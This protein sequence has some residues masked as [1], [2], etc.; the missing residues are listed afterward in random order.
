M[1]RPMTGSADNGW[2]ASAQAWIASMGDVG[3]FSRQYVL[4]PPMLARVRQRGF[5][6]ALDVGCGEGRFCRLLHA[7]G[8]ATVGVEPSPSLRR[9]A[10]ARDPAGDYVEAVAE[11]LPFPAESFDLVVCYLTLID[12]DDIDAAI[13]EAVRVLKPGG[14]L[15]IAN[16]NSFNTAGVWR[17]SAD[18][19]R[20]FVLDNYLAERREWAN[21]SGISVQNWHRPFSRYMRP[22]LDAGLR[23]IYFDEPAPVGGNET[24][25]ARY[26]RSPWFHIMEWRKA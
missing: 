4:D 20:V 10:L 6:R 7:E 23:L 5:M 25:A 14:S 16:L 1:E 11:R 19:A 26:R 21:W 8:V 15:L 18:G 24:I 13:A 22:L 3:D 17:E 12:I 9:A 2:E